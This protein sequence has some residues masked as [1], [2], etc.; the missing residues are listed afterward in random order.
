MIL[1]N[2]SN[3]ESKKDRKGKRKSEQHERVDQKAP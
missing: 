3:D 1:Q 2:D